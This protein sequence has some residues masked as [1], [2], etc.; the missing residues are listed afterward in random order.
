MGLIKKSITVTEQQND[1]IKSRISFGDYGNDSEYVRDL[2]RKDRTENEKLF[3][4]QEA[5]QKGIDSGVSERSI[6]EIIQSVEERLR[7]N[8]QL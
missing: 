8:G 3:K 5:V 2:I 7:Q 4:L 1:W 6:E